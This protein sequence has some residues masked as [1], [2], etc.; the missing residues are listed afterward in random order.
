MRRLFIDLLAALLAVSG[1]MSPAVMAGDDI[2]CDSVVLNKLLNSDGGASDYF[3]YSVAISG[4]TALVG[5]SGGVVD[6]T[7]TGSAYIFELQ[8]NGVW[9]ETQKLF[10]WDGAA[11]DF[12]GYSVAISG[13]TALIGAL[14]MTIWPVS[15]SSI[16]RK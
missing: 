8:E 10:A 15:I 7:N 13:T 5:A 14:L 12:F 3:G 11:Y 6:G 2:Q 1:P 16:A 4:T 9:L